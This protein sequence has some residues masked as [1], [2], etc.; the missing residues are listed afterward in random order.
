MIPFHKEAAQIQGESVRQP[1]SFLLR[2]PATPALLSSTSPP[3]TRL[4]LPPFTRKWAWKCRGDDEVSPSCHPVA[5]A[6]SSTP[7]VAAENN[8]VPHGELYLRGRKVWRAWCCYLT[9]AW[10]R[11]AG[12]LPRVKF[13][14][15][16]RSV[17]AQAAQ[18]VRPKGASLAA[19]CSAVSFSRLKWTA[20]QPHS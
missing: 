18:T 15:P 14:G 8:M 5:L 1:G 16:V 20:C 6:S 7:F 9:S 17:G 4:F 13:V 11:Y 2:G 12:A 10:P 3:L 19:S